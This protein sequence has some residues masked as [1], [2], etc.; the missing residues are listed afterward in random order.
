MHPKKT[1]IFIFFPLALAQQCAPIPQRVDCHPEPDASEDECD[2]R[3]CSWCPSESGIPWCVVNSDYGYKMDG[4]PERTPTGYRVNLVR[5]TNASYFG[6]DAERLTADFHV[7]SDYRLRIK[8]VMV[9]LNPQ[10]HNIYKTT[11]YG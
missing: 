9:L 8:V 7:Q 2:R 5:A 10:G 11:R 3:G 1:F 4:Q 6:N